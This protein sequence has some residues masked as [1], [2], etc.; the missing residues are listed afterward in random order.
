MKTHYQKGDRIK[1]KSWD[2]TE[3]TGTVEYQRGT[4]LSVR[5][6]HVHH[7]PQDKLPQLDYRE[8]EPIDA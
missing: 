6:D 4:M 1:A 8:V 3:F 7:H 2:G 5:W